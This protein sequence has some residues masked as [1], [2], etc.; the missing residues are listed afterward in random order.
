MLNKCFECSCRCYNTS[1]DNN[2]QGHK[3]VPEG[4][5]KYYIKGNPLEIE[6]EIK[7]FNGDGGTK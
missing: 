7:L 3:V 2:C 6:K 1:F 4:N 5:C